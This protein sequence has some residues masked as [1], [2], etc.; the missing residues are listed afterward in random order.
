MWKR[1]R[2]VQT[3]LNHFPV[4]NGCLQTFTQW[5]ANESR[6]NGNVLQVLG[7]SFFFFRKP[8]ESRAH[9]GCQQQELQQLQLSG[10]FR[11]SR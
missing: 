4:S 11:P 3:D 1:L 5:L 2:P 6:W 7:T 9:P 8:R 10:L